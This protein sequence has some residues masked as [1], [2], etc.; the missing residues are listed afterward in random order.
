MTEKA[1][2]PPAAAEVSDYEPANGPPLAPDRFEIAARRRDALAADEL[3]RRL[4]VFHPIAR[5]S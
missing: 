2:T 1:S 5:R 4:S 3:L